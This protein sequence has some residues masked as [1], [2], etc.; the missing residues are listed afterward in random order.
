MQLRSGRIVTYKDTISDNNK[1]KDAIIISNYVTN[2]GGKLSLLAL[3]NA[4]NGILKRTLEHS[5]S[6]ILGYVLKNKYLRLKNDYVYVPTYLLTK[7]N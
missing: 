5:W 4:V 1:I 6:E 3:K 2:A 7:M